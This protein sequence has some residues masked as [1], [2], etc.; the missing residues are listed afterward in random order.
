VINAPVNN[1]PRDLTSIVLAL[2]VLGVILFTSFRVLQPFLLSITWATMIV[3]ASW[4]LM[5]RLQDKLGGRRLLAVV[6]MSS[7]LIL[8]LILPL[9]I[10][11]TAIVQNIGEIGGLAQHLT[12]QGVPL[13]PQWLREV[14]FI[15]S[16]LTSRWEQL[17]MLDRNEAIARLTPYSSQILT[18]IA[19]RIGSVGSIFAQVLLTILLSIIIYAKGESC[20][21]WAIRFARCLGHARGERAML[22]A[23]QAIRAVANGVIL[24]ALFQA[25][26]TLFGLIV[27]GVSYA[28]M[29]SSVVF[30][31]S[32]IQIGA[33]PVLGG[34]VLWLF[35]SGQPLAAWIFLAWSVFIMVADNFLRPLLIRRGADFPL[36]LIFAGVIGGLL[37]FGVIGIFIGPVVLAVSYTWL[38][39]WM[40]EKECQSGIAAV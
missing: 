25:F 30:L 7:L 16:R 20:A 24:T 29:L 1:Q 13:P 38:Q 36:I 19:L 4:P 11:I 17:A 23:T 3:I 32:V 15:G 22:L 12:V 33:G 18:W 28:I 40:K 2:L 5:L 10:A 27:A 39:A 34:V 8:V 6:V 26:M 31:L 35:Y 9:V 21:Q 14:P 37:S